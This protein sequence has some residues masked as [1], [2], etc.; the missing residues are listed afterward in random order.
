MQV[1]H[2]KLDTVNALMQE[3]NE[4]RRHMVRGVLADTMMPIRQWPEKDIRVFLGSH[5]G[6]AKRC[7]L[8]YFTLGNGM[9]P[10]VLVDWCMAQPG[11]LRHRESAEHLA[12]LIDEHGKGKFEHST[13]KEVWHVERK[14][15][16]ACVTPNFAEEQYTTRH[17]VP[18]LDGAIHVEYWPSG[19]K[20]WKEAARTLRAYGM[21]LPSK[22]GYYFNRAVAAPL[23]KRAY[24]EEP[25]GS[26][27]STASI[28]VDKAAQPAL[29]HAAGVAL[30][31]RGA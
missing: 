24:E 12:A 13:P 18:D 7:C 17:H 1:R 26:G 25:C 11:Y 8:V 20:F 15:V 28:A 10:S 4:A 22:K 9:P 19:D 5:V 30:A 14:C 23:R 16:Q 6:F 3:C 21:H 29:F 27:Q 2:S 31:R